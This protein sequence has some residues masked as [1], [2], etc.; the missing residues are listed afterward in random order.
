M[1]E[2]FI[3]VAFKLNP[4][5]LV[6]IKHLAL[7]FVD[8]FIKNF[9]PLSSFEINNKLELLIFIFLFV[10]YS[11]DYRFVHNIEVRIAHE[12]VSH[13]DY[14]R[15]SRVQFVP[16]FNIDRVILCNFD[17]SATHFMDRLELRPHFH[18]F[19]WWV[20][21]PSCNLW[22]KRNLLSKKAI[23]AYSIFKSFS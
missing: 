19:I 18:I 3:P 9:W 20:A 12:K 6:V 10:K 4:K 5:L 14:W 1:S 11:S 16:Y 7:T 17:W 23:V 22:L 2:G 8:I 15:C 13:E 21:G